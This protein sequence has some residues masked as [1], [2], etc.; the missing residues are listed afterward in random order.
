MRPALALL[1]PIG[2]PNRHLCVSTRHSFQKLSGLAGPLAEL[3]IASTKGVVH[4]LE[5]SPDSSRAKM[6]LSLFERRFNLDTSYAHL[7]VAG[8]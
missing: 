8:Q 3:W 6:R 4:L 1:P 2:D 7:S 5:K